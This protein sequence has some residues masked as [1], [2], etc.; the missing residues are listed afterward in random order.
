MALFDKMAHG[1]GVLVG[2]TASEALVGH[3]EESVVALLLDDVADL[4]PLLLGRVDA[5]GVVGA[6]VE[7]EDAALR[8]SLDVCE[9]TSEVKTDSVLVVVAVLFDGE[10]GIAEDGL[11]VGPGGGGDV[12]LLVAGVEALEEG[13]ANAEGAGA[14]NG[15]GDGDAVEGRGILA[16]GQLDGSLGELGDAGD[17][18]VLLVQARGDHLLLSGSDRGQDVRLALVISVGADTC[19][20]GEE[21]GSV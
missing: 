4:L 3:V 18:G 20:R 5:G 19:M 21:E 13:G 14:R 12:D 15:L 2:V 10:A 17:A 11:V 1:E 9:H 16:V 6:G 8:G 7:E